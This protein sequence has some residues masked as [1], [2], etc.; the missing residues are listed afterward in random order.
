MGKPPSGIL[1]PISPGRE[2]MVTNRIHVL[3]ASGTGTTTLGRA[4]AQAL[5]WPHFDADK[6]YWQPSDPP[7]LHKRDPA[8]RRELLR[9]DLA[10]HQRWVLSGALCGWGDH[11]IPRFDLVVFL[12]VPSAI[13]LARLRAREQ[14]RYGAAAL[15]PGGPH[16]QRYPAFMAWAAGYDQ[17]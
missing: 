1:A 17:G 16:H 7:F 12:W 15:A 6:Y 10:P 9:A 13:R 5:G 3:G 11:F 14:D 4:L 8:A 2:A